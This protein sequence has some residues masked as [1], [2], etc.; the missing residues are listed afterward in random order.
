VGKNEG[1]YGSAT[2]VPL[3]SDLKVMK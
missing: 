1:S 2:D 3:R